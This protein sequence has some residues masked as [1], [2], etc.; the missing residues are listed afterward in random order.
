MIL[1]T[2]SG[3]FAIRPLSM[4]RLRARLRG[5]RLLLVMAI[6]YGWMLSLGATLRDLPSPHQASVVSRDELQRFSL[7]RL[8]LRWF[9]HLLF[10]APQRLQV[11][12]AFAPPVFGPFT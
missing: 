6:A 7:F 12:L 8:G 11:A 4:P 1:S 2:R 3:I 5:E 10:H 9:R